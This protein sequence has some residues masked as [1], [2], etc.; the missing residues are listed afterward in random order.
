MA[1]LTWLGW[2]TQKRINF[3]LCVNLAA[4]LVLKQD[5]TYRK[6]HD[7]HSE[8]DGGEHSHAHAQNQSV[9]RVNAAVGVKQLCLHFAW[10]NEM[11]R[12]LVHHSGGKETAWKKHDT[13][14]NT[15]G[16]PLISKI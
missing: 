6:E 11:K 16:E 9:I 5:S 2:P 1:L 4:F 3:Q 10:L 7:G 14:I 8:R 12:E 15:D 13:F